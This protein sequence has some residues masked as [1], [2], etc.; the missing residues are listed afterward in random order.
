MRPATAQEAAAIFRRK[1]IYEARRPETKRG[2][3]QHARGVGVS[4]PAE[5]FTAATS[6]A[7]G[8]DQR[9]ARRAAALR[10]PRKFL[11][12][13]PRPSLPQ[14]GGRLHAAIN[15]AGARPAL[16]VLNFLATTSPSQW[17]PTCLRFLPTMYVAL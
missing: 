8:K 3:N 15:A 11:G 6:E 4:T 7:T 13:E 1:Q 10:F 5:R 12:R 14:I 16:N 9:T 17:S 2:A